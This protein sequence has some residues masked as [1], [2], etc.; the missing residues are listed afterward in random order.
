MGRDINR[1]LAIVTMKKPFAN[2]LNSLPDRGDMDWTESVLEA[3]QPVLLPDETLE[4]DEMTDEIMARYW[5]KIALSIFEEWVTEPDWWPKNFSAE[6]FVEWFDIQLVD[7]PI[8]DLVNEP[9][10]HFE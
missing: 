5:H 2:W 10:D 7:S 6:Q 8:M 4:D 3:A 1:T 9:I